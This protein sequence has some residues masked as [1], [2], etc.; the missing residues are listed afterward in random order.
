MTLR[1]LDEL[2]TAIDQQQKEFVGDLHEVCSFAS[3]AG[4]T[5]NLVKTKSYVMRKM[6]E[7]G[8]N[9]RE[10]QVPSGNSL[11]YGE[12]RGESDY[13]VLFY[14]HYD[15][16]EPGDSEKWLSKKPFDLTLDDGKLYARGISDNKGALFSRIHAVKTM[17][18]HGGLPVSVKFLVEGDEET[19]SPSMF[20]YQAENA[21]EFKRMTKADICFWENGR[22]DGDGRPWARFGVRGACVFDLSVTT[23]NVDLHG[24]MGATVPSAS[25]RLIW[26]LA[27]LKDENEN[28][29]IDGFYND[30]I[31]PTDAEL[32]ILR[33]LP[34]NADGQKKKLGLKSYLL[35]ANGDDVKLRMHTEPT[36]SVCGLEAGEM[37]KGARGIVPHTASARLSC[38][39]VANQ[40]PVKISSALRKHLDE[41]GFADVEIKYM[42]G[43]WP[44]KTPLDIPER[45]ALERSA[46]TAYEQPM[47]IEPTQLGGGPAIAIRRAWSEMPIVG[48]GPANN[49]ANHH[50]PNENMK[51]SDYIKS[52][53]HVAAFLYEAAALKSGAR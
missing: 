22:V 12:C 13:T 11:I 7:Y 18:E 52:I 50:A 30:V 19:A 51:L 24:R 40:D 39:L 36:M 14:N 33:K 16:V 37:Y 25:W 47:V 28:I 45:A 17:L 29:A 46:L 1:E 21:D 32:E 23:C 3:V 42:G 2:F 38:Y 15:V 35:N 53:K 4:N 10:V 41:K 44:I 26:A 43:S 6:G 34:Y 49:S 5:S 20:K 27:S 31:P 8:I 48:I 9:C